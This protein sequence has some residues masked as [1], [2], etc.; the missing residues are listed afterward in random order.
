MPAYIHC[1][2][3]ACSTVFFICVPWV[4]IE[5]WLSGTY[6]SDERLARLSFFFCIAWR[7]RHLLRFSRSLGDSDSVPVQQV[8]VVWKLPFIVQL[9]RIH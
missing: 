6:F 9:I 7:R 2:L 8:H 4:L 1:C 5:L 3:F